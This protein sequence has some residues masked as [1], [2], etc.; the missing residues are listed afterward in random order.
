MFALKKVIAK[1]EESAKEHS[2]KADSS[3]NPDTESVVVELSSEVVRGKAE[4]ASQ[5]N[6][7]SRRIDDMARANDETLSKYV[8]QI[9]TLH[10]EVLRL[11][12]RL[13]NNS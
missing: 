10:T 13:G 4:N 7:F 2:Q 11:Q 6:V 1:L 12:N 8:A 3:L 9:T 5:Q